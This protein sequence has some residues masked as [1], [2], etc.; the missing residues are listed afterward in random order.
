MTLDVFAQFAVD[1]KKELEGV[2]QEIGGGAKLLIARAGNKKYARMLAREV[3]KHQRALDVKN[4]AADELSDR[5]MVD[6][7]AQTVLIG[8]EGIQYK[9][10]ALPYSVENAKMLLGVKDFRNLVSKLAGDFEAY[11]AAQEAELVKS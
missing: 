2:W 9:K 10:Q 7:L 3:E 5:I 11:R 8:W 4:E 6:V 1:E